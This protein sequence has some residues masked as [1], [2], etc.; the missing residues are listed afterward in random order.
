VVRHQ[1]ERLSWCVIPL[2]SLQVNDV[3]ARWRSPREYRERAVARA[4]LDEDVLFASESQTLQ[5]LNHNASRHM[6]VLSKRFWY[7]R[8][9]NASIK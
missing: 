6:L 7:A 9:S 2:T 4:P 1:Q 5:P 8:A 3:R